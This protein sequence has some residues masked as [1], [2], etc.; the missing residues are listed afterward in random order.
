M[1]E[2]GSNTVLNQYLREK[3]HYCY[4]ELKVARGGTFLF[5]KIEDVQDESLPALAKEGLTWKFSDEDSRRKPCDGGCFPPLP[6][7]LVIK[8]GG[9][10]C[11]IDYYKIQNLRGNGR[12]SITAA[13]AVS[14][15]TLVVHIS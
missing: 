15:A 3:K 9:S 13:E 14:L 5:S 7:Y 1:K 6:S 11:F 10:Y 8:F 4:Y 12:K 2:A